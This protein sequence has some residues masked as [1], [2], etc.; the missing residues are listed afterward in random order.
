MLTLPLE[1][2]FEARVYR[3][4]GR[5]ARALAAPLVALWALDSLALVRHLWTY[6]R[7][8]TV[9]VILPHKLPIEEIAFFVVIPLCAILTFEAAN[10]VHD[11][12]VLPPW[13]R[14]DRGREGLPSRLTR[15][16][17]RPSG[18]RGGPDR[19]RGRHVRR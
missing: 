7:R 18:R 10:A 15:T 16:G 9:G 17:R 6:S 3:R 4:V 1:F 11:G 14:D 13:R 12:R 5:L 19:Y 8:Y 2:V